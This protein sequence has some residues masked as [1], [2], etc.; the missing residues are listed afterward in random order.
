MYANPNPI[1][2][3]IPRRSYQQ[4]LKSNPQIIITMN[5][6]I[7]CTQQNHNEH[8]QRVRCPGEVAK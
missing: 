2:P 1:P 8:S 5:R 6:I 4:F 7:N 3:A